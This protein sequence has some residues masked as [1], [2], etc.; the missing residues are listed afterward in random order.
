[1]NC[2]SLSGTV[3]NSN[4]GIFV[5][6][7]G[8]PEYDVQYKLEKVGQHMDRPEVYPTLAT[9]SP[10]PPPPPISIKLF[11]FN[12]KT[13]KMSNTHKKQFDKSFHQGAGYDLKSL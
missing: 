5:N 4:A 3:F 1:M 11:W 6:K 13:S 12:Q 2:E 8:K 10:A 9:M 7:F